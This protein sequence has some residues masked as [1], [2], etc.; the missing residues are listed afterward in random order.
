MQQPSRPGIDLAGDRAQRL[1]KHCT[2]RSVRCTPDGPWEA[3]RAS[4]RY[5]PTPLVL[6]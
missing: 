4:A 5:R 3:R 2:S 6:I 1:V